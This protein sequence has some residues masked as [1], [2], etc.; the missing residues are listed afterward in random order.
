MKSLSILV[1]E[2]QTTISTFACIAGAYE[3]FTEANGY[4]KR[5]GSQ[6]VFDMQLVGVNKG[7]VKKGELFSFKVDNTISNI[8]KSH[9]IIIPSSQVRSYETATKSNKAMIDFIAEQYRKGAEVASM[10]AGAFMLAS[11]GLLKGRTCSTHWAFSEK[12]HTVF[13]DVDLRTDK[14]I[15]DENGI[16]TNG[17]AYSFLHLLLYLVEKY[18]DRETA[19]YCAKI[20][21]IDI[22]RN[23]QAGFSIFTGHKSHNDDVILKAQNFM[24]KYYREKISIEDLSEKYNVGRRNFD[25]RFIRATSVTPLDYLQRIRIEVAKKELE[26]TRKTVNEVMYEVGYN[27]TKAFR[28]VFSRITGISPIEYKSKYTKFI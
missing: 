23:L 8:E 26:R 4:W 1:P 7:R 28:E 24:E 2:E 13:P 11:T 6:P 15:T 17:G 21:Q 3:V 20:F 27:D 12:F 16:Y 9:L 5:T 25:R 14:L 10:C 19:V 18:Y 22:D